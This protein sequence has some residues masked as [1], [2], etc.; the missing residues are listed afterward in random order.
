MV[1]KRIREQ[2]ERSEQMKCCM[3]NI[4]SIGLKL[5]TKVSME[6]VDKLVKEVAD[7]LMEMSAALLRRQSSAN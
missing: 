5:P 4:S 6:P 7:R 3:F 2:L 1:E